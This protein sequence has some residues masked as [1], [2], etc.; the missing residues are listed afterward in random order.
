MSR[1]RPTATAQG[2]GPVLDRV[3]AALS[4]PIRR[5]IV[6]QLAAGPATVS[7][8]AAP[9]DVSLP[10][11][12]EHLRVLERAGLLQQERDGR[13]RHCTLVSTP[14]TEMYSWVMRYRIFW[15]GILDQIQKEVEQ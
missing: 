6:E 2:Q 8:L 10:T 11:I 14:L 3:F 5:A 13:V 1:S 9:H 15:D 12:S 4:H 7:E